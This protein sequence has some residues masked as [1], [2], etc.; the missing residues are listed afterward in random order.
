[1]PSSTETPLPDHPPHDRRVLARWQV[2]VVL[3]LLVG[4]HA[5]FDVALSSLGMPGTDSFFSFHSHYVWLG[6]V[7]AQPA[8]LALWA[9]F[10]AERVFVRV[11]RAILLAALIGLS[12]VW[13]SR[14]NQAGRLGAH[15]FA[16]FVQPLCHFTMM[17]IPLATIRR[18]RRWIITRPCAETVGRC[19]ADFQFS[20]ARLLLWITASAVV[21]AMGT[22]LFRSGSNEHFGNL[23]LEQLGASLVGSVVVAALSL[24]IVFN[25]GAA[26]AEKRNA[27]FVVWAIVSA[28]GVTCVGC[29]LL[30]A[31]GGA[32]LTD[33]A[34]LL[35]L[36]ATFHVA[37]VVSF[38][39]IRGLGYR[40]MRA[41]S[42]AMHLGQEDAAAQV[43]H[44][45]RRF[46]FIVVGLC[47]VFALMLGPAMSVHQRRLQHGEEL[48]WIRLGAGARFD[49]TGHVHVWFVSLKPVADS[50][51]EKL[52]EVRT[53]RSVEFSNTLVSDDQMEYVGRQSQLEAL[54]LNDSPITDDAIEHLKKLRNLKRLDVRG[55]RVTKE[56]ARRLKASLPQCQIDILNTPATEPSPA[57]P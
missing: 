41:S 11:P 12:S 4:M 42:F 36:L 45:A 55:S 30:L 7:T 51:L 44:P 37:S 32:T 48:E 46:A 49:A 5:F 15:D 50:A 34:P 43:R 1:M 9:A 29:L 38:L 21:L 8:L 16:G 52:S 56:G 53:L 54:Y 23:R 40:L 33:M 17:L 24:P 2:C 6:V 20:L 10:G 47:F 19:A 35:V 39:V 3:C 28:T 14:I 25:L 22:W 31:L 27:V 26:L 18:Y 13:T 57:A